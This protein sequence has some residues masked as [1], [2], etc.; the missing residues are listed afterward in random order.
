MN[1][2]SFIVFCLLAMAAFAMGVNDAEAR[3][4]FWDGQGECATCHTDDDVSCAGCHAHGVH[5][6]AGKDDINVLAS[7]DK[8]TYTPGETV[9][10][11]ITGGYRPGWVR[12]ILY[13]ENGVEV[14]RSEGPGCGTGGADNGCGG[15]EEFPGPIVLTAPAPSTPGPYIWEASWY[16]NEYDLGDI[17]E[18]TFFGPGW[19]PDPDNPMHGEEIVF[20]NPF[21]VVATGECGD[22]ILDPATEDCDDGEA[23]GTTICG[24]QTDCTYTSAGTGCLRSPTSHR[25]RARRSRRP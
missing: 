2:F 15:G 17:G 23:N 14:D 13:N 24:C 22:G 6:D 20:T 4:N 5:S 18:T 10:V 7:T 11:S 1:K 25:C 8:A 21:D 19:T 16:G 3:S 12:A 9:T